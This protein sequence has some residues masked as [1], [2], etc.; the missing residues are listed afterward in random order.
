MRNCIWNVEF[1]KQVINYGIQQKKK[2]NSLNSS[3]L[4]FKPRDLSAGRAISY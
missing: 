4:K 3:L 2:N 1:S